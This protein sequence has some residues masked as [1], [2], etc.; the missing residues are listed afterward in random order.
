MDLRNAFRLQRLAG[1]RE[2]ARQLCQPRCRVIEALLERREVTRQEPV[3]RIARQAHVVEW[4]PRPCLER[5]ELE[6]RRLYFVVQQTR[7]DL[8]CARQL[9]TIDAGERIPVFEVRLTEL[10]AGCCVHV[11]EAVVRPVIAQGRRRNR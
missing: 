4:I 9:V 8:V 5:V 6:Q 7:V 1:L 10:L 3:N 2:E 11:V